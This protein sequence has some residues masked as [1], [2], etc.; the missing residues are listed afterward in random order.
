MKILILGGTRF[1]G[2]HLTTTALEQGHTVTL[3]NRG[4]SNPNAFSDVETLIGDRDGDL[5]ALKGREW[6][7]VLDVNSYVPRI[8]RESAALLKDSV[9]HFT[10]ISTMS[11]YADDNPPNISEDAPK[12]TLDDPNTEAVTGETYGG[13]KVLCEDA[14][15]DVFGTAR[16]LIIRPGM[17][18]GPYDHTYRFNYWPSRMAEGGDVLAPGNPQNPM[19]FIDMRDLARFVIDM[20]GSEQTGV[21]NTTGPQIEFGAFLETTQKLVNPDAKLVW[22]DEDFLLENEVSPFNHLP[23]WLPTAN[24]ALMSINI[25]AAVEAGLTFTPLED[26]LRDSLDEAKAQRAQFTEKPEDF[27]GWGMHPTREQEILAKWRAR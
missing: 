13:L 15:R 19:Q 6:D 17:I 4:R 27:G 1:V 9:G 22:V 2:R 23:F 24:T 14:G 25:D 10:Y 5:N 12:K 18:V 3:F 20:V 8:V 21:Y 26:T 11:V 7:A 16:S